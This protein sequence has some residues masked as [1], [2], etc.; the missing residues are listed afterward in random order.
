MINHGV[1]TGALFIAVGIIYERLHT[2]ELA[3]AA[4]LGKSMPIFTFFL[5]VFCLSSLAFPGTNS[6][7]GEFLVLSGGFAVS[8][9][10]VAC[11]VPGVVASA[12][13]N[14]RMLQ[15]IAF[16]GI[17]NPDHHDIKDLNFREIVTLAPLLVFVFW[18]G[19]HPQPFVNVMHASVQNLIAQAGAFSK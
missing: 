9:L 13:Y 6:F 8:L 5:G 17:N 3:A 14:F 7:I 18:I 4:G 2:R 1:T 16:G 11:A 12:A 19:L 15:R 10:L